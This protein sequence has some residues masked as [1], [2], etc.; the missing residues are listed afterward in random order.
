MICEVQ[1][2]PVEL[3]RIVM[4]NKLVNSFKLYLFLKFNSAGIISKNSGVFLALLRV[5]GFK[6]PKSINKHLKALLKLDWIGYNTE[7]GNYFI[8]S[9]AHIGM[10]LGFNSFRS[11][12]LKFEHLHSL[13]IFLAA[14]V[15]NDMVRGQKTYFEIIL[16][17]QEADAVKNSGTTIQSNS[18]SESL[19]LNESRNKQNSSI[20]GP[21][22][23]GFGNQKLAKTL[24]ICKSYASK[25]KT[26]ARNKGF[27]KRK[28]KSQLIAK[29][30]RRDFKIR[31]NYYKAYPEMR[32]RLFFKILKNNKSSTWHL[33][34]GFTK[35]KPKKY[36]ELRCQL[37]DEIIPQMKFI[38]RRNRFKKKRWINRN[39]KR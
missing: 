39:L 15:M 37:H 24:N 31:S 27:I 21:N 33:P 7:T 30:P 14:S 3:S 34:S 13:R 26:K 29:L 32:G 10:R 19:K 38:S 22:Y 2:I 6:S 12:K 11:T 17:R 8:R 9:F 4:T 1:S 28:H 36:I 18:A 25:L 5:S 35:F 16:P 20:D 23:Y